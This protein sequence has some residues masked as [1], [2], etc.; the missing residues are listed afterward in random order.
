MIY[1]DLNSL[2]LPEELLQKI[3]K[4]TK[5]LRAINDPEERSEYIDKK[6]SLWSELKDSLV[7]LSHGKCWYCE[8]RQE[9]SF[10]DVDHFR[11]KKAVKE[12]P[13][14]TGYWWLAFDYHNFRLSCQ[15]CNRLYKEGGKGNHFPLIDESCRVYDSTHELSDEKPLLLDP[16]I[17]DDPPLLAFYST[18]EVGAYY[19]EKD[20]PVKFK[21]AERSIAIYHLYHLG[22]VEARKQRVKEAAELIE[23]YDEMARNRAK[24][25]DGIV[26]LITQMAGDNLNF[27]CEAALNFLCDMQVDPETLGKALF[28]YYNKEIDQVTLKQRLNDCISDNRYHRIYNKLSALVS[29]K[30]EYSSTVLNYLYNYR[31]QKRWVREIIENAL[32]G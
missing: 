23:D 8:S 4:A 30:S 2:E 1:I 31:H 25:I 9:R 6:C 20:D 15:L 27:I 5:E 21:R 7:K 17:K 14:H 12:A 29:R 10:S 3:K 26:T 32:A 28:S 18:G 22:V 16:T 19:K 13:N 11:P 24:K